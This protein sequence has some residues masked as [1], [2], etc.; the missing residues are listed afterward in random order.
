MNLA[1]VLY[2]IMFLLVLAKAGAW[3]SRS[4]RD[5]VQRLGFE[6]IRL[7]RELAIAVTFFGLLFLASVAVSLAASMS[8]M[9]E[10]MGKALTWPICSRWFS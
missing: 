10:D 4:A 2:T 7:K 3:K 1:I 8:H 5:L 6:K 9:E